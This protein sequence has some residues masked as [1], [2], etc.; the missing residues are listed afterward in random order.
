M[1]KK[2]TGKQ[3]ITRKTVMELQRRDW[4]DEQFLTNKADVLRTKTVRPL[5]HNLLQE[6][7]K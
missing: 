3:E 2:K 5:F 4:V 1:D 7:G 6:K